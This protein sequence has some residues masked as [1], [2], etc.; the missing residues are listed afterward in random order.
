MYEATLEP[1]SPL[2]H[3][4]VDQYANEF[5]LYRLDEV[6]VAAIA[7]TLR[8]LVSSWNPLEDPTGF[9]SVFRDWRR[10]L[11]IS[12]DEPTTTTMVDVYGAKTVVQ[13]TEYVLDPAQGT[14]YSDKAQQ[15]ESYDTL[16]KPAVECLVAQDSNC[17]Q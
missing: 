14:H 5:E 3:K 2:V 16:R 10:A 8:R 6:V 7:P 13:S 4:L 15:G 17:R 12:A 11:K 1:F 9:L